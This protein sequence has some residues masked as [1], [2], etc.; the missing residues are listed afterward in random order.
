[1]FEKKT[2]VIGWDAIGGWLDR[3]LT[4]RQRMV[5]WDDEIGIPDLEHDESS[6]DEAAPANGRLKKVVLW[7]AYEEEAAK[8]VRKGAYDDAEATLRL[9][10]EGGDALEANHIKSLRGAK[11]YLMQPFVA[12][13]NGFATSYDAALRGAGCCAPRA[14]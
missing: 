7:K 5:E 12:D 9:V 13:K 10:L 11:D 2:P 14:N 4:T 1:M 8:L 6:N 3:K